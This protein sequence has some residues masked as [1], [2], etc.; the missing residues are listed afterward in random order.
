MTALALHSSGGGKATTGFDRIAKWSHHTRI[1]EQLS[2]GRIGRYKSELSEKQIQSVEAIA[3][4]GIAVYRHGVSNVVRPPVDAGRSFEYCHGNV[5][6][7][8]PA[9][10]EASPWELTFKDI[11]CAFTTPPFASKHCASRCT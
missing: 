7:H 10:S 9:L 4:Y 8:C 11:C 1:S 3:Q 2:P 5:K 6:R